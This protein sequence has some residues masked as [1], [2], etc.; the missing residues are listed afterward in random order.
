MRRHMARTD[1]PKVNP[2]TM[3][4]YIT[5]ITIILLLGGAMSAKGDT[6]RR[7]TLIVTAGVE[8]LYPVMSS[9]PA[10]EDPA[11]TFERHLR[12]RT[13]DNPRA[14]LID[15]GDHLSLTQA[16]E[17]SYGYT[18]NR[19]FRSFKYDAITLSGRDAAIGLTSTSGYNWQFDPLNERERVVT[20]L[21]VPHLRND[22][23]QHA[24]TISREGNIPLRIM[25]LADPREASGA[26]AHVS[27]LDHLSNEE[28]VEAAMGDWDENTLLVAVGSL[29][30]DTIRE[31]LGERVPALFIRRGS[32]DD[33][34]HQTGD[35]WEV[36][37]P[38]EGEILVVDIRRDGRGIAEPNAVYHRTF[39]RDQWNSLIDDPTPEIGHPLPN[40]QRILTDF[41][42]RADSERIQEDRLPI[43]PE[44]F[45]H[46]TTR[47][48]ITVYHV[49]E[50]GK[51]LRLYRLINRMKDY[52]F[53]DGDYEASG[54]P[55]FNV[56]VAVT[57]DHRLHEVLSRTRFDLQ[58]QP[59]SIYEALG[60]LRGRGQDDWTV[61]PSLTN[62]LE[63]VWEYILNSLDRVIEVDRRLFGTVEE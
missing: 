12:D 62:G 45:A 31:K 34:P 16:V 23:V 19:L 54:W 32:T 29:D 15:A 63:E 14:Y 61:D 22:P 5:A 17:T 18:S 59:T 46:L 28:L 24:L 39:S 47:S 53:P 3:R 38:R 20:N 55:R 42:P 57:E 50:E 33:T 9:N 37:A 56:I 25:A 58:G 1:N 2:E 36:R 7:A 51:R 30:E 4:L 11:L 27:I 6:P 41:L 48:N 44:E 35:W 40:A 49:T 60:Q 13:D 8:R 26:S 52:R 21:R 43:D 10:V